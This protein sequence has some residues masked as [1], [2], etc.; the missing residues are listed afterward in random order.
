MSSAVRALRR[1]VGYLLRP[2][3]RIV[4]SEWADRHFW[5]SPESHQQLAKWVTEPFQ[6][7]WLD[8]LTDHNVEQITLMGSSRVGKTKCLVD[9][10]L[11]IM[12]DTDP[13]PIMVVEPSAEL[14]REFSTDEF[15]PMVRDCPQL[16]GKVGRTGKGAGK[17]KTLRKR[18]RGGFAAFRGAHA[19]SGLAAKSIRS[20]LLDEVDRFPAS[21]MTAGRKEGDPVLLGIRR[22]MT[23]PR[24]KI[25]AV[26][27]PGTEPSRIEALYHEG[28]QQRYLVPC[29]HCG[30]FDELVPERSSEDSGAVAGHW[31][32]WPEGSPELA[33]FVCSACGEAIEERHK[34]AMVRAGYWEA[35]RPHP[36]GAKKRHRSYRIWAAYSSAANA[37]WGQIAKEWTDALASG[38]TD[39]IRVV[40]NTLL[41]RVWRLTGE[42]PDYQPL[43]DRREPYAVGSVPAPVILLTVGV[44]VQRDR[45]P[46][47]VIGWGKGME[48]WSI[49]AGE[50][51]GDTSSL[52]S[53]VW[54][55]LDK[56]LA[57]VWRRADG[58]S[59]TIALM[60]IDSGDNTQVVYDWARQRERVMATKG[61]G[62]AVALLSAPRKVTVTVGGR[63]IQDGVKLWIIGSSMAKRELYG[64]LRLKRN[65]DGTCPAGYCHWPLDPRYGSEYFKQLTGEQEIEVR[66]RLTGKI[67]RKWVLKAGHQNHMLD[68]RIIARAVAATAQLD[69][70]L[71]AEPPP[72]APRPP[73]LPPPAPSKDPWVS[74]RPLDGGR[75]LGSRKGSFWRR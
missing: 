16:H 40:E 74:G 6:R 46:F 3:R 31:M 66:N 50:F 64:W 37:R 71:R 41:G 48:S 33:H 54:K 4:G 59:L 67:E 70:E 26:S 63:S 45:M 62:P 38:D 56:L 36:K 28:D 47:E 22:T 20:L 52:S 25:V 15:D 24:R 21:A 69:R 39:K 9:I 73:D 17:S 7:A 11:A 27:S 49:E 65:Q 30:V 8:D 55:E 18:F 29:P 10:A 57:A 23:F 75:N 43:L 34:E 53:P 13:G 2:P 1:K 68:C 14:A 60:G 32:T 42:A 19:A 12:I 72:E 35:A 5:L 44:D 51:A 61:Y 58:A